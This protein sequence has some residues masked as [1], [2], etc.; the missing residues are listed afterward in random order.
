[1]INLD[2]E[3]PT[4]EYWKELA[5]QRSK[6]LDDTL[7]ENKDITELIESRTTEITDLTDENNILRDE[8]VVLAQ[9]AARI[10]DLTDL[11]TEMLT[12]WQKH[13]FGRPSQTAIATQL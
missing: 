7:E 3:N 10:T 5:E 4:E 12:E 11:L 2:T 9:K 13:M 8:N 1:M 6:A